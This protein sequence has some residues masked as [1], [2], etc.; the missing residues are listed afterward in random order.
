MKMDLHMIYCFD[1]G[2]DGQ[3]Y[4][5]LKDLKYEREINFQN[6]SQQTVIN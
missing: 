2:Q 6:E 5:K 4:N 3:C 1:N